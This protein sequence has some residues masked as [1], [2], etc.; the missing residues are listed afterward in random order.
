MLREKPRVFLMGGNW[1]GSKS[2]L[3]IKEREAHAFPHS[4]PYCDILHI[5]LFSFILMNLLLVW[6]AE[7]GLLACVTSLRGIAN[8]SS[9]LVQVFKMLGNKESLDQIIVATPGLSSDPI[10]LG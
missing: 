7:P 4:F 8:L 9:F 5:F 2:N 6:T 10:A 1:E 3:S